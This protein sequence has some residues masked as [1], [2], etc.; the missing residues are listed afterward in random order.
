MNH[1]IVSSSPHIHTTDSVRKIMSNV[2][3]ALFPILIASIFLFGF[4]VLWI[5]L[6]AIVSAMAT[7]AICQIIMKREITVT[8]GSAAITGLLLAFN[9]P[10]GV[11]LWLPVIGSAFGIVFGKMLFGGLGH[12][13]LNPALVGR[14]FI[15]ASWPVHMTTDWLSPRFGSISGIE[16]V[17]SATPLTLL[18]LARKTL[19]DPSSTAAQ[20]NAAKDHI[21]GL[22]T[23]YLDLFIGNIGGCIGETSALLILLGG[24]YL[25]AT[26]VIDWRVPLTYIATVA[27]L[28]W[29]FGGVEGALSGDP[30]LHILSGGLFLGA[31]FMA[32]DMVT[33]P[34]T[35]KGRVIFAL[36]CG[37]LTVVI[38]R[39]GGYPEGVSYSI[40]LMNLATP[41]IDRWAK[42][43]IFG[44][45]R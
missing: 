20:I 11:P 33:T 42:P 9:L 10:P 13:L 7:E 35:K 2:L 29:L 17:T 27:V 38:R 31:F 32:T 30:L 45:K 37:L 12:N 16:G 22:S 40:L 21:M 14:A 1:L 6:V 41:L 36:G 25:I 43:R 23:N 34:I 26:K 19:D 3:I 24:I 4:K 8:D 28:G 44:T 15:M 5:S 18:K 39:W